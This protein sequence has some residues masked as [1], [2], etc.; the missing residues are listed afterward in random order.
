MNN[1]LDHKKD[2]IESPNVNHLFDLMVKLGKP[3]FF[4]YSKHGEQMLGTLYPSSVFSEKSFFFSQSQESFRKELRKDQLLI[5]SVILFSL[6]LVLFLGHVLSRSVV[7]PILQ[8]TA[9]ISRM[10]EGKYDEKV[11][12]ELS[13]E[14]GQLGRRFNE[15]AEI[16]KDKLFQMRSIGILNL[17]M[18]HDL[19]RRIMLKYI[20]HLL[21]IKY[22]VSF[23]SI[24]FF[25]GGLS[26]NSSDYP[27]WKNTTISSEEQNPLARMG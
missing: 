9:K 24:G 16:I 2:E 26:S 22:Q 8:L 14:I 19:P 25:E 15:M 7:K 3:L 10:A 18:N 20:L 5:L 21:C 23:G 27:L 11:N 4:T 1:A 12:L 13:D 6:I 17:L